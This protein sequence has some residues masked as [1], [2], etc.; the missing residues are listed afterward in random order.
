MW[1]CT[2]SDALT[3]IARSNRIARFW[4]KNVEPIL[5]NY[6]WGKISKEE[7]L[8]KLIEVYKA[9]WRKKMSRKEILDWMLT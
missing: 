4:S 3:D 2:M 1:W 8:Q 7:C 9:T 5:N 6:F